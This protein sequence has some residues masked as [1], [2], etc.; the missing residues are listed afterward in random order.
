MKKN[1]FEFQTGDGLKLRACS[2]L[3]EDAPRALVCLLHGLGEHSGRYR[4]LVDRLVPAGYGMAAFNLRG[5]GTSQGQR[6]HAPGLAALMDDI[7]RFFTEVRKRLPD[8]PR[9]LYGHSMGGTL[10]INYVLRMHPQIAGVI[11]T[12]PFLRPA[13]K[14][15]ILKLMIAR[16]MYRLWPALSLPNGLNPNHVSRDAAVVQAYTRDSLVHDRLSVQLGIDILQ[17]GAWALEH[18]SEFSLP[19]LLMQGG[20]DLIVAVDACRE[21]ASKVDAHCEFKLWEGCYH[22]I[23]NEPEKEAVFDFLLNWLV[24]N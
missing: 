1:D 6:G 15:P 21:F 2:W 23:H 14:V 4:H 16:V 22:E 13:F 17:A 10:A 24:R 20:A 5:H 3:P 18:A 7:S 11:V 9:F 19:L 12:G 8:V